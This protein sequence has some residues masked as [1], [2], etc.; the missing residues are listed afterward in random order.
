MLQYTQYN[1]QS[2]GSKFD[3]LKIFIEDIREK[4]N[5]EF[6]A[7]CLQECQLKETDNI[8]HFKLEN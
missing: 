2:I 8:T 7:I 4:Y 5:F 6:N 1:I 3:E